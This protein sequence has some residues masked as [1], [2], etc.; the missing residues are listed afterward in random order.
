MNTLLRTAILIFSV[1][2]LQ[3]CMALD[4]GTAN[5][6]LLSSDHLTATNQVMNNSPLSL[7]VIDGGIQ[8]GDLRHAEKIERK[9]SGD[10][11]K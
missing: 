3:G 10:F 2:Q 8:K 4:G 5:L 6:R 7:K 11:L 9:D 1:S